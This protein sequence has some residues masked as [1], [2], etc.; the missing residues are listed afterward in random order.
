M[1]LSNLVPLWYDLGLS[2]LS[3]P[4]SPSSIASMPISN[5]ERFTDNNQGRHCRVP[6]Y[7]PDAPCRLPPSI[8]TVAVCLSQAHAEPQVDSEDSFEVAD[9]LRQLDSPAI[10]VSPSQRASEVSIGLRLMAFVQDLI[11]TA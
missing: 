6:F 9:L 2:Q 3:A 7:R 5:D 1:I 10:E 4:D 8:P 11:H